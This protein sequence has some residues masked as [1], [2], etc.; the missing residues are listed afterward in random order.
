MRSAAV[1]PSERHGVVNSLFSRDDGV[2]MLQR[3]ASSRAPESGE[4]NLA[5]RRSVGRVLD[6]LLRGRPFSA[7]E[8]PAASVEGCWDM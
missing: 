6:G 1:V 8:A 7:G 5:R 4:R 2:S 3:A